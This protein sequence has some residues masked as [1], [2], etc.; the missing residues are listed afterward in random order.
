MPEQTGTL[1]VLID[2]RVVVVPASINPTMKT[3]ALNRMLRMA[4]LPI[5]ESGE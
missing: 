1:S 2:G 4:Q 3:R 5:A